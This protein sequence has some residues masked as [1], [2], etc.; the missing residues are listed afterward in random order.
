M[1]SLERPVV[2]GLR[3]GNSQDI[4]ERTYKVL[5]GIIDSYILNAEP[6][7]SRTLSKSLDMSL[8]PATIRNI[9]ADLS[10]MGYLIQTHTSGG[11]IPTD[12]AYRLYVDSLVVAN[13]LPDGIQKLIQDVS[14]E[15]G[16]QV[17]N[18][19]IKTTRVL[20]GLTQFVCLVSAP[21]AESSYLKRIEFIKVSSQKILVILITKAGVIRNK[22]IESSENLSQD[23]LNSISVFLNE[24]FKDESLLG[25]RNR[26]LE[27]MVED[28]ARYDQLLAQA[29]RLGKK[30]FEVEEP[31]EVY[32]DGQFNFL[33]NERFIKQDNARALLDA[34]E[35]RSQL[36]DIMDRTL[37]A[38]GVQIYIGMEN[39]IHELRD[40]TLI[41]SG[42]GADDN[43]LG[44]VGVIGPTCMD[45]KRIIPVVDYTAKILSQ[46]IAE[47]EYED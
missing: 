38:D 39:A 25:I 26:I 47:H 21:K 5:K 18:M 16:S 36:M 20:A 31:P 10:E 12:K 1:E 41:A 7:G 45:Y 34:F 2:S 30:A 17:E 9:M 46:A 6:V 37:S 42:Y 4:D 11:R 15:G 35:H 23:F 3:G 29:V 8:S 27:S 22:I 33:L 43:V 13:D 14:A 24:Q 28:K 40:Y 44:V 19:L 32:M